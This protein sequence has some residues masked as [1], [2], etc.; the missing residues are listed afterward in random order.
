MLSVTVVV[1]VGVR[2]GGFFYFFGYLHPEVFAYLSL[3]FS[4]LFFLWCQ[5]FL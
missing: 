1:V 3:Y 5:I 4:P 2:A